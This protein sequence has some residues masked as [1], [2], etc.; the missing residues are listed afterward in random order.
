MVSPTGFIPSGAAGIVVVQIGIPNWHF[1]STVTADARI[2]D[3]DFRADSIR[4]RESTNSPLW[5][6]PCD[7]GKRENALVPVTHRRWKKASPQNGLALGASWR[8]PLIPGTGSCSLHSA[9]R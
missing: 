4:Y 3:G 8:E 6:S 2:A 5:E 7:S 1:T 9:S